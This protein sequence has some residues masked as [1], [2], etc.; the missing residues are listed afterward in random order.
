MPCIIPQT[1]PSTQSDLSLP[2][3]IRACIKP[4]ESRLL[5]ID[6]KLK[7]GTNDILVG[8]ACSITDVLMTAEG[9]TVRQRFYAS[10]PP[11][12]PCSRLY[13]HT[14]YEGLHWYVAGT[15]WEIMFITAPV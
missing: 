15:G 14:A 13:P 7:F 12:P 10:V 9:Q 2:L 4:Q 3:G 5:Y 11:K 8:V 1:M 6:Q